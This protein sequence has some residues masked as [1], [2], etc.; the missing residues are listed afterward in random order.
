MFP[1]TR[2]AVRATLLF[3][4]LLVVEC[5]VPDPARGIQLRWSTGATDL[6]VS[7]QTQ[8][9]LVIQAD[10]AEVALPSS[11]RL[12][13]TAD[14][15]GLQFSAFD[16]SSA[17]LADTAKADSIAPPSTPA[18]SAANMITAWYCSSG[19]TNASIAYFLADLPGGGHGKMKIVT[20]DPADPD[21]AQVLESNE[22]TFNGGIDG[23][24]QPAILRITSD[25][26]TTTLRVEAIGADL[27]GIEGV[28]ISAPQLQTDVPLT[29][30]SAGPSSIVASAT[31]AIPLPN[32]TV[33]LET[34][35][36]ALPSG[37]VPADIV[38]AAE[39]PDEAYYRDP[40]YPDVRPKDFAFINAPTPVGGVWRNQFHIF[41]IRHWNDGRPDSTNEVT[42]GHAWSR[43]LINWDYTANSLDAFHAN[44]ADVSAWDHL[45]VWAPSIVQFGTKFVMFYT[46][47]AENGDQT[48]GYATADSI[49]TTSPSSS[50]SRQSTYSHSPSQAEGGWVSVNHP[51]QFRDP[52]V[53][54]DP[55]NPTSQLLMFYT[56]KAEADS[57]YAVGVARSFPSNVSLWDDLGFYPTTDYAHTFTK[58]LESPHVFPDSINQAPGQ[59]FAATWRIMFTAGDWDFPDSTRIVFFDTKITGTDVTDRTASHW[60]T[61]PTNLY[62]Y[63]HL[64]AQSPEYGHQASEMLNVNGTYFWA[65]FDDKD[66]RFRRVVWGGTNQF[67]L[68]NVGQ[69]VGVQGQGA[70]KELRLTVAGFTPSRGVTRFRLDMPARM[71]TSL[72]LYDVMGRRVRSLVDREMAA[73]STEVT[74]DGRDQGGIT[75]GTGMYFARMVAG[76]TSHV[77]RVPLVW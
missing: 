7:Q 75:V 44:T 65:G 45:H 37:V 74:W 10:S 28:S 51:W 67:W 2:C 36:G 48:I 30:Q 12:Q 59:D 11:W 18:D 14:S 42:F 5:V 57:G 73:G 20:L 19:G 26:S 21:S 50:W 71:R 17:C 34:P 76:G 66:I 63:L 54:A 6:T 41:Y 1:P 53:M 35:Q 39:V 29:M 25:H 22:V 62:D 55:Q 72:A 61:T 16:P 8:A 49:Y 24:Y 68:T 69:I 52:Y 15:L 47:V 43:D 70:P 31:I 56:A 33:L 23:D 9:V 4:I 3:V 46:G 77:V 64:T 38:E 60:S 27:A 58:R 40:A 32:C 13:W